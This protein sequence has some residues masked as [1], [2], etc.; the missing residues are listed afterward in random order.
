MR[1]SPLGV[2]HFRLARRN[3]A[4]FVQ[5]IGSEALKTSRITRLIYRD[6]P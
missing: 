6:Q 1:N 5:Q 4:L 2:G 3:F